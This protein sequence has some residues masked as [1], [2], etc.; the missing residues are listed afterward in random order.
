[1]GKKKKKENSFFQHSDLKKKKKP[2]RGL[3]KESSEGKE[4]GPFVDFD[5]KKGS[6]ANLLVRGRKEAGT[7]LRPAPGF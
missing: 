5:L 6:A 7:W 4:K 2:G 1:V 3:G